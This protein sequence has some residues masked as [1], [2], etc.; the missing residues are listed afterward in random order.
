MKYILTLGLFMTYYSGFGQ[1]NFAL[2][3]DTIAYPIAVGIS[4]V[5]TVDIEN[6]TASSIQL[7]IIRIEND[8]APDW[9]SAICTSTLCYPF[10]VDSVSLV[11]ASGTTEEIKLYFQFSTHTTDTARGLF[12][13][14][15]ED[16]TINQYSHNFYGVD[17]E[18]TLTVTTLKQI[19]NL[20][21]SPNPFY[22]NTIIQ[23]PEQLYNE[24]LQIISVNGKIVK[25]VL[26]TGSSYELYREELSKGLYFL[27][28]ESGKYSTQR[29][30]IH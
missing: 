30:L 19:K 8:V 26:V 12:L 7:S 21:I 16:D 17:S 2:T 6:T 27:Q 22:S 25:S 20:T 4:G 10:M 23:F 18:Q 29:L 1:L 9:G 15:N 3:S 5:C 24:R 13:F 28:F 14:R 11:I